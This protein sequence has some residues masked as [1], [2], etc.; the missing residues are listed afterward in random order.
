MTKIWSSLPK[1][2]GNVRV[3][4]FHFKWGLF[5]GNLKWL[6]EPAETPKY[7]SF[8]LT[9]L[10]LSKQCRADPGCEDGGSHLSLSAPQL[11]R[12]GSAQTWA[13]CSFPTESLIKS[14]VVVVFKE[15]QPQWLV[16]LKKILLCVRTAILQYDRSERVHYNVNYTVALYKCTCFNS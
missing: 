10:H 7:H 6:W 15:T 12:N 13:S 9:F 16:I 1:S 5:K 2:T 3:C 4:V 14:G 11:G 8:P